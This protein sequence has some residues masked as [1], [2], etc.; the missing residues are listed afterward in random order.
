MSALH[1]AIVV[2]AALIS[3]VRAENDCED[4]LASAILIGVFLF[5]LVVVASVITY[6]GTRPPKQQQPNSGFPLVQMEL[7]QLGNQPVQK[8]DAEAPPESKCTAPSET[9]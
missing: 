1:W 6:F 3:S 7:M 5:V 2:F 8:T 9:G 4:K